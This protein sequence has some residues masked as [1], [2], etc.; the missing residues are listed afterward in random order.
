MPPHVTAGGPL[1][2]AK[3]CVPATLAI[4]LR[5]QV[6]P[7]IQFHAADQDV[8]VSVVA[9]AAASLSAR[10]PLRN[11][12]TPIRIV[13]HMQRQCRHRIVMK[14]A[15]TAPL[16]SSNGPAAFASPP[17]PQPQRYSAEART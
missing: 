13:L 14:H 4:A 17:C 12:V 8:P 15:Y 2:S 11:R 9:A 3:L 7:F 6:N 5:H 1:T 16:A 10:Q